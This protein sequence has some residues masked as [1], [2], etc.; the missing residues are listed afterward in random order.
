VPFRGDYYELAAAARHKVRH[1]IYPVPDPELPFLGV[2]FTRMTDGAVECGPN[3]VLSF[4]REGYS[5]TAFNATDAW[6]VLGFGG[7]W[8]LFARHWHYGLGE[9]QRAF[10]KRRFLAAL[11]AYIPSLTLDEIMP[12]RAGIRAQAL[13]QDGQLVDDFRF[14]EGPGCLHVLNA[15]S[16]AATACLAIA[17][18][19]AN[20]A[21]LRFHF[22]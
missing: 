1:L 21:T 16:P 10:S 22:G 5:R 14:A 2:H 7:S 8:R 9:Y 6:A 13:G 17:E 20:R 12:A 11:Q 19:I 15:P 4:H 18:E 3:A